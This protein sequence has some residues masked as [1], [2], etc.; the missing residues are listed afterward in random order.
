M[1]RKRIEKFLKNTHHCILGLFSISKIVEAHTQ[2]QVGIAL[3]KNANELFITSNTIM[4]NQPLI[5][6]VALIILLSGF[7]G[8]A[9]A[10]ENL[11]L[12]KQWFRLQKYGISGGCEPRLRI[13][14][15]RLELIA[16][17]YFL[18]FYGITNWLA[19]Y[20]KC[21]VRIVK[22]KTLQQ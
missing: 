17:D 22:L 9:G 3:E 2:N 1:N 10:C 19:S 5:R 7:R 14:V 8:H 6:K 20:F 13:I 15:S 21:L 18:S 12:K 16:G 4:L 11:N